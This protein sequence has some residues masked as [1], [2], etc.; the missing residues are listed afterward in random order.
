MDRNNVTTVSTRCQKDATNENLEEAIT[1]PV[2]I[3]TDS[4]IAVR[5]K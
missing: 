2:E 1:E 4:A 5:R 3:W